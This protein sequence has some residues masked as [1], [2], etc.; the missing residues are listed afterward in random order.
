MA[1]DNSLSFNYFFYNL[2]VSL[3]FEVDF[4]NP[5]NEKADVSFTFDKKIRF[6]K[7][8]PKREIW[9]LAN[10]N[11]A[12]FYNEN[13]G[14]F[15]ISNGKN[16][17]LSLKKKIPNEEI[18]KNLLFTPMALILF[19]RK[20]LVVHASASVA[21]SLA[22]LFIGMSGYGKSTILL[23]LI[24]KGHK[25]LSEDVSAI[26]FRN[27]V[28]LQP[29]FPLIKIDRRIAKTKEICSS[30]KNIKRDTR[31][32]KIYKIKEELHINFPVK[33]NSCYLINPI[34]G[35]TKITEINDEKRIF[36]Q[37]YNN[38]WR[39]VPA[40]NCLESQKQ[41]MQN[42]SSFIKEVKF[43]ELSLSLNVSNS[44]N[45]IQNHIEKNL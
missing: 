9:S 5:V 12:F 26:S 24:K 23:E 30:I 44:A 19:Q 1:L 28:K 25:M 18:I 43:F 8:F 15:E 6:P 42:I 14:L 45:Y 36:F 17:K 35:K 34:K 27:G 41:V 11:K 21:N 33:V 39:Q 32:R 16:V 31:N 37:M 20:N 7:H 3:P 38:I 22:F 2:V 29:S 40:T 13:I 4:L 10:I